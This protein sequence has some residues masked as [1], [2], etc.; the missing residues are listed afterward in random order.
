MRV[1]FLVK[2]KKFKTLIKGLPQIILFVSSN[3][4]GLLIHLDILIKKKNFLRKFLSQ[5]GI[6]ETYG[7]ERVVFQ[8]Y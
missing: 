8:H 1:E 5:I 6:W 3:G 2:G 4:V 7:D